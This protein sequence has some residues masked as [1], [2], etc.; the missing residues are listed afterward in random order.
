[1]GVED[2]R[3]Y[4]A[5]TFLKAVAILKREQIMAPQMLQDFEAFVDQL[6]QLAC[7]QEA[8]LANV[9]IPDNYLDPI[10]Q[11][12]MEDPVMLP[13]SRTIMDRKVIERHIMSNDDDPFNRAP[14]AVAD[15]LPQSELKS[16][17]HTFCAA[18]GI[19]LG[20]D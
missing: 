17:I 7:D 14:L 20:G 11:E 5:K 15:L 8:A 6:N 16:E 3:S 10:M 2:G 9:T 1:M 13:T 18:H 12:I 4:K 19:A